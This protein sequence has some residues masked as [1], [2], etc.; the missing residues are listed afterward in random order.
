M[1]PR[2]DRRNR[3]G[4]RVATQVL[5]RLVLAGALVVVWPGAMLAAGGGTG[6]SGDRP[7]SESAPPSQAADP[8]V[9]EGSA[10]EADRPARH[11]RATDSH[12]V[13]RK[14]SPRTGPPGDRPSP[15]KRTRPSAGSRP[16][17]SAPVRFTNDDLPDVPLM[18]R[19]GRED[20]GSK[21][22]ESKKRGPKSS[23]RPDESAGKTAADDAAAAARI[24]NQTRLRRRIADLQHRLTYLQQRQLALQNPLHRG[25]TPAGEDEDEA[26]GGQSNTVHL[27]WVQEQIDATTRALD[28]ARAAY[29]AAASSR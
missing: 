6:E 29:Q 9:D 26:V 1:T 28:E 7:A 3:A 15:E 16:G 22:L 18:Y 5:G 14:P 11:G 20:D 24:E 17:E 25:V 21:D 4:I 19:R 12:T 2:A 10:P 13:P 8:P 23:A 27:D